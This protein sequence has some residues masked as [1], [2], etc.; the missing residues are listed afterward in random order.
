MNGTTSTNTKEA[1]QEGVAFI[2]SRKSILGPDGTFI[3]QVGIPPV[4]LFLYNF[5][6]DPKP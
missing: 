6:G 5:T 1:I 3:Y 2:H 4:E